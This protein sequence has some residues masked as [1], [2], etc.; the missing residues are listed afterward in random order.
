MKKLTNT[1]VAASI[2]ATTSA[3]AQTLPTGADSFSVYSEV[4]GWTVFIDHARGTCIIERNDGTNAIQM[5]LSADGE[6]GYM[7]VFTTNETNITQGEVAEISIEFEDQRYV[8]QVAGRYGSL[9]GGFSGG[10]IRTQDE[11]FVDNVAR[12]YTM[13]AIVGGSDPIEIDLTGTLKAIE[14]GRECNAAQA[15]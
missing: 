15:S 3:H 9:S 14:A 5:G 12:Q 7:G 10:Y 6:F 4:E 13:T 8:G 2:L 11:G 1:I